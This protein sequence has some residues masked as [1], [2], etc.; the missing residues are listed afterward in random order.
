MTT[1][2]YEFCDDLWREIKSYLFVPRIKKDKCDVKDCE[3]CWTRQIGILDGDVWWEGAES[4]TKDGRNR[5]YSVPCRWG[6]FPIHL[7]IG[8]EKKTFVKYFCEECWV[9]N[10]TQ[11]AREKE[12]DGLYGFVQHNFYKVFINRVGR[13]DK[14]EKIVGLMFDR[15][16]EH[17][18]IKKHR[19]TATRELQKVAREVLLDL[20]KDYNK[21]TKQEFY[22]KK[23]EMEERLFSSKI[24]ACI[25]FWRPLMREVRDRKNIKLFNEGKMNYTEL[26]KRIK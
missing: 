14:N 1:K 9:E 8:E 18:L 12:C 3:R 5:D 24:N 20:T 10:L 17:W 4:T 21:L 26:M 2:N 7:S 6:E 13:N 15:A 25:S 19:L 22:R 11:W 23:R 16:E